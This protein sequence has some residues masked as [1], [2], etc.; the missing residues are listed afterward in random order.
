MLMTVT[1]RHCEIATELRA[2]AEQILDR[3]A[4]H[5]SR[6]VDGTVVFDMAAHKTDTSTYT[7]ELRLHLSGGEILVAHGEATDHRTALDRA[8][9]KLRHQLER[10]HSRAQQRYRDSSKT[11]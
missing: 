5:A 8:E 11:A 3:L 4:H 9:D 6:A 7:A 1:A 10:G 2:R